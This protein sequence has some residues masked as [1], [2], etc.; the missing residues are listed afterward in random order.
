MVAANV[1]FF[2][3]WGPQDDES[4]VSSGQC[5]CGNIS[6]SAQQ[7][8]SFV[9][10]TNV[11][12]PISQNVLWRLN[13]IVSDTVTQPDKNTASGSGG[14]DPPRGTA[15]SGLPPGS[16]GSGPPRDSA[17]SGPPSG[18]VGSDPPLGSADL[19]DLGQIEAADSVE[20]DAASCVIHI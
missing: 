5:F 7:F 16:V 2:T 10:V 17:G 3:L 15:G 8:H 14:S 9:P 4:P 12:R 1:E 6:G 19:R 20:P 18:S 11:K 13:I